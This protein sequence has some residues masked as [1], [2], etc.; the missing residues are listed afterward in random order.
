MRKQRNAKDTRRKR[1]QQRH[2]VAK[3]QY[4]DDIIEGLR[5]SM[6]YRRSKQ[7]EVIV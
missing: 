1:Y 5:T 4:P 7:W 3:L 6:P 2:P